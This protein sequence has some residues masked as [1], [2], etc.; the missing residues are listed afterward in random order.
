MSERILILDFGS[1]FTQLIARRIRE[2]QVY[3]EI[4]PYNL[5]LAAIRAW[6]PSGI[7]LSGGPSSVAD[8]DAP[9][10]DAELFALGVPVL[11][12]CYGLQLMT[13]LLG[14]RVAKSDHREYG[15]ARLEILEAEGPFQ[16]L[17]AGGTEE[18]WMSHGDRIETLPEGFVAIGR[19]P[20]S[21]LAAIA[22]RQ[23]RLFGVQFHLEVAHTPAGAQMLTD[24]VRGVCGCNGQWT[25]HSYSESAIAA[26]RAQVG[27]GRVISALSGGVDSAVASILVHRA[28]GEQ[29][30]CIFVDNG[31][32]RFGEVEQ[33]SQVFRQYFHIPLHVVDARAR[34]L[35][36]LAGV[37]DPER[38][39]KIIGNLFI[40]V[41]DE[42][43]KALGGADFLVQGTLY[44]DVIESVSF[45]G[46]SAT[47]KSHH[48][49]GGLP[50]RMRLQ[51]VEPLRELFK[52]EVREL[53]RELGM[54]EEIVRRQPF[55]GPGLAIRC[56]GEVT[57]PRLDV[58]RRADRIVQEE[59]RE[60][61]YYDRVWQAF[62]VLLPVRS[63]GVMGDGRTYEETLAIRAV[64]SS[65]GMT[66][67]WAHLPHELLARMSTRIINEVAGVNRVVYD[68]SSKPPA[69]IEWE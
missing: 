43:A 64:E 23:R 55:P 24:F 38:K 63:V 22:H 48:N 46:P 31:L 54:P 59:I 51:L 56:L 28:V 36:A 3:C 49:V 7:V 27:Q 60:A 18:V 67:D 13:H 37:T 53:G 57:G 19:S 10:V 66:A 17:V 32:L 40:E 1:Q 61:G 26:V 35:D 50:E 33:V 21:P 45:K 41:F 29:L 16:S 6:Q 9:L 11:G 44:P 14:G 20:G 68:I 42:E 30:H 25:M 39:R 69:T 58:L 2:A 15:R 62:A 4:H 8:A 47:I 52:D 34:F 65:D 5:S 12:I